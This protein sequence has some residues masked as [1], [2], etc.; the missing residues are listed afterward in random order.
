MDDE[1][2]LFIKCSCGMEVVEFSH[3]SIHNLGG[4]AFPTLWVELYTHAAYH[5]PLFAR[6]REAWNV[7]RHGRVGIG[8]AAEITEQNRIRLVEFLQSVR[9]MGE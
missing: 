6:I 2:N 5:T 1:K 9:G 8:L 3:Y 7:L 4:D